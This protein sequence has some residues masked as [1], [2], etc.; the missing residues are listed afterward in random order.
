MSAGLTNLKDLDLSNCRIDHVD[1]KAF[2]NLDNHGRPPLDTIKL[3]DNSL[4]SIDPAVFLPL[5]ALKELQTYGNP[6]QCNCDL[7]SFRDWLTHSEVKSFLSVFCHMLVGL[8]M[9]ISYIQLIHD[10]TRCAQ[11]FSTRNKPWDE[12]LSKLNCKPTVKTL[13]TV[14]HATPGIDVNLTCQIDG[15]PRFVRWAKP[16]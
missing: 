11:P 16:E 15:N 3:N 5:P 9:F 7:K 2:K 10:V 6:W 4:K 14:I 13:S 12:V 8:N 1:Q